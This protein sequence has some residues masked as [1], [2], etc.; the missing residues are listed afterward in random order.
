MLQQL[1]GLSHQLTG[2][3][4]HY[5]ELFLDTETGQFTG[6]GHVWS[7]PRLPFEP[8]V[9]DDAAVGRLNASRVRLTVIG[10]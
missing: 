10:G 9:T 1:R 8:A 4:I 3:Q 7:P 5:V 6:T 2:E